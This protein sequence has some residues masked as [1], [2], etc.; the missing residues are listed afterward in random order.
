MTSKCHFF[1]A[2]S[3]PFPLTPSSCSNIALPGFD[4]EVRYTETYRASCQAFPYHSHGSWQPQHCKVTL[5]VQGVEMQEFGNAW[6][7]ARDKGV[8]RRRLRCSADKESQRVG[9]AGTPEMKKPFEIWEIDRRRVT[10]AT[11][12]KLGWFEVGR[13][14]R[15]STKGRYPLN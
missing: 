13:D 15:R 11:L 8:C 9:R 10:G 4:Y 1:Q 2:P 12:Q 3:S 5:I 7:P 14:R 6:Q